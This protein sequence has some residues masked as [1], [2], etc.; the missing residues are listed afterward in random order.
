MDASK[1][2]IKNKKAAFHYF[3]VEEYTAGIVLTGPEIKS[4]RQ[5]KASIAEAYCTFNPKG[6]LFIREMHISPYHMTTQFAPEPKK[7]R[8]LLLTRRE[9]KKLHTKSR[10]KGF[11]IVPTLVFITE[12]GWAKVTIALAK[13]KHSYDKKESIRAKDIKKDMQRSMRDY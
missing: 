4:I 8:K 11:T 7:P 5:G 12:K 9:L 2:N 10:E 3:L 1:V 6:E 13:G